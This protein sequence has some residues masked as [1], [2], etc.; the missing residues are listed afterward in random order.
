MGSDNSESRLPHED[1]DIKLFLYKFM[2]VFD[3]KGNVLD[4]WH[5]V[6]EV[7]SIF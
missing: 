4:T 7:I 6:P 3:R 5:I 2:N 1:N